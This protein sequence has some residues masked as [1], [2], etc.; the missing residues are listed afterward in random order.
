[1]FVAN[2]VVTIKALFL[3]VYSLSHRERSR[4]EEESRG[5]GLMQGTYLSLKFEFFLFHVF[6]L[7]LCHI[8]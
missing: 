1:M 6:L 8:F 5:E 2:K 4:G 3:V 7:V